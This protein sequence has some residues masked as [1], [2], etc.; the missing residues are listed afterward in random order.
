MGSQTVDKRKIRAMF[1]AK[2]KLP[3]PGT[4]NKSVIYTAINVK[5]TI[6]TRAPGVVVDDFEKGSLLYHSI[7]CT[8]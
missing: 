6:F 5:A 4:W 3:V 2:A 1:T 8:T 7:G